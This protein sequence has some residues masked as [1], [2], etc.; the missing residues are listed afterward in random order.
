MVVNSYIYSSIDDVRGISILCHWQSRLGES[1]LAKGAT[2]G[3][4]I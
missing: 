1:K 2:P 4:N 3:V